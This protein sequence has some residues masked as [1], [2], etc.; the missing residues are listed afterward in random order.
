MF[1]YNGLETKADHHLSLFTKDLLDL[2][3]DEEWFNLVKKIISLKKD[4]CNLNITASEV[5]TTNGEFIIAKNTYQM[6]NI[7]MV[8]LILMRNL[9]LFVQNF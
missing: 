8:Y 7:F 9:N 1:I 4:P 6:V 2:S 5:D 3:I